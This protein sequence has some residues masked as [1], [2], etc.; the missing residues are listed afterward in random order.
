MPTTARWRVCEDIHC[1]IFFRP[2]RW[3]LGNRSRQYSSLTEKL[4]SAPRSIACLSV[5]VVESALLEGACFII[6]A[7]GPT[8][9]FGFRV[10]HE[11]FEAVVMEST[12]IP[13]ALRGSGFTMASPKGPCSADSTGND[14]SLTKQLW[15]LPLKSVNY[16]QDD[17]IFCVWNDL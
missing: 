4:Q 9:P 13:G 17:L 16:Q 8:V 3:G 6:P 10:D 14:E 2:P 5:W 7:I 15:K 12:P 1:A 11:V